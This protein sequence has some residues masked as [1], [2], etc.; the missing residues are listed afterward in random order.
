MLK[1]SENNGTGEIGLVTPTH[2][3]CSLPSLRQVWD[4][5]FEFLCENM[6]NCN[7]LLPMTWQWQMNNTNHI[8]SSQCHTCPYRRAIGCREYCGGE[9]FCYVE[10]RPYFVENLALGKDAWESSIYRSYVAGNAVDGDH[11][12][13]MAKCTRTGSETWPTWRVDLGDI[14]HVGYVNITTRNSM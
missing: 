6:V 13:N 7:T 8:F 14:Y 11:D 3:L 1:N 5:I 9:R 4:W 12:T 10:I 2:P